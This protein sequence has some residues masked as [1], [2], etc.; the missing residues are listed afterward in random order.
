M[1]GWGKKQP[2]PPEEEVQDK[3]LVGQCTRSGE[4]HSMGSYMREGDEEVVYCRNCPTEMGRRK[5]K[6]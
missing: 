2:E 5:A 6:S 4:P 3:R 1:F